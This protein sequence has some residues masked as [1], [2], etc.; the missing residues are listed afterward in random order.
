MRK[1]RLTIKRSL[2]R[3]L[4]RCDQ[5][6]LMF[7]RRFSVSSWAIYFSGQLAHRRFVAGQR[8]VEPDFVVS[9]P[10]RLAA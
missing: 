1:I 9:Q 7:C 5:S 4:S 8:V 6:T 2:A 3:T 10:Q